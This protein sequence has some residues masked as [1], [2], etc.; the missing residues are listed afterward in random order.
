MKLLATT[1]PGL[2]SVAAAEVAA[3]TGATAR[4]RYRGA[5]AFGAD[6][7]AVVGLNCRARSLHRVLVVL[8]D[9]TL[10]PPSLAAVR[11]QTWTAAVARWVAP[12]QSF[13]VR[14][15]RHGDH[16]FGSPA[17]ADRVGQAVR[18]A[19]RA[20]TGETPAVDLEDPDVVVRAFVREDDFLLA[21]D[22][23]GRSLHDRAYRVRDHD[24]PLRPTVAWSLV[25]L[26]GFGPG[27]T[28]LDPT[29]GTA[30]VPIEAALD[31]LDR[32]PT[33]DREYAFERL[34]PLRDVAP[35]SAPAPRDELPAGTTVEGV[36]LDADRV[37][38][39][40]ENV[41]AAGVADAV[42][43]RQGD[44]TETAMT[45]DCVVANLPFGHRTESGVAG[46][47]DG[48]SA[49]LREGSWRRF[50]ALTTR[51]ELLS[52][53]VTRTVDVRLGRLEATVVVADR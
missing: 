34:R 14:A 25:H 13:A 16:E 36:E 39:A 23:T 45:A 22:T 50:V 11:D 33:P 9:V 27:D 1:N 44:A 21:V 5:V 10:S 7:P 17:V 52:V 12:D 35:P 37:A 53:P 51:P 47:Y 3:L 41:A 8:R 38:A 24:A 29:C 32:P 2:E 18:D 19:V 49:R 15:T 42:T 4:R 20:A 48:L 30:P 6:S 28:L 43:V 40:R 46:L 26:A 31:A